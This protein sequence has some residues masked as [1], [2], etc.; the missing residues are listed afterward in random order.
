VSFVTEAMPSSNRTCW[1]TVR[2]RWWERRP[3]RRLRV[4]TPVTRLPRRHPDRRPASPSCHPTGVRRAAAR[5]AE[6]QVAQVRIPSPMAFSWRFSRLRS[7]L[8]HRSHRTPDQ[9]A[10]HLVP[11]RNPESRGVPLA[12]RQRRRLFR[13]KTVVTERHHGPLRAAPHRQGTLHRA[14]PHPVH[15]RTPG[16]RDEREPL[17]QHTGTDRSL[18]QLL[19]RASGAADLA[20]SDKGG[21]EQT[22]VV[23]A[24]TP[25]TGVLAVQPSAVGGDESRRR[26]G[27]Q[28]EPADDDVQ[29]GGAFDSHPE[30]EQQTGE[31]QHLEPDEFHRT[32]QGRTVE[33]EERERVQD[34]PA[35]STQVVQAVDSP[36]QLHGHHHRHVQRERARHRRAAR[37]GGRGGPLRPQEDVARGPV[38]LDDIVEGQLEEGR[39]H[40]PGSL[41][42]RVNPLAQF[43]P[44]Q[45]LISRYV[46]AFIGEQNIATQQT[47]QTQVVQALSRKR[48]R[49]LAHFLLQERSGRQDQR[50]RR[51]VD[52]R[53]DDQQAQESGLARS[54]PAHRERGLA[55]QQRAQSGGVAQERL[56]HPGAELQESAPPVAPHRG[57]GE[58][59]R[60]QAGESLLR[61]AGG[62]HREPGAEEA[63]PQDDDS[64][65]AAPLESPGTAVALAPEPGPGADRLGLQR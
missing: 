48:H 5:T 62:L 63:A 26:P 22:A 47:L 52:Q 49:R 21:E 15:R 57:H 13:G 56:Q 14:L 42:Q 35:A 20:E 11:P 34:A 4:E 38:Q 43:R 44:E 46:I 1:A 39:P 7:H 19:R 18:R 41:A 16:A 29:D 25:R 45:P 37:V 65:A 55:Q 24:R 28:P 10:P 51:R 54:A 36:K 61:R 27:P 59:P 23:V 3:R 12:P 33:A 31:T 17:R 60:P 32:Q 40:R 6:S 30:G 9:V 8:R 64:D 53:T 2:A 50:L 58:P